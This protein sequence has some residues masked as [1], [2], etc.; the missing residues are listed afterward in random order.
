MTGANRANTARKWS[1]GS[2]VCLRKLTINGANDVNLRD[3]TDLTA[4]G[5]NGAKS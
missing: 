4:K 2:C 5:A 1:A 3:Q